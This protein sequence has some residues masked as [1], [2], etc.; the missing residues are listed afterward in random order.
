MN[1]LVIL[2]EFLPD[3]LTVQEENVHLCDSDKQVLI[4]ALHLR[5]EFS[6]QVTVL[7]HGSTDSEN[8]ISEIWSYAPDHVF[9]LPIKAKDRDTI[10]ES[11]VNLI[12][13]ARTLA[14]T[15]RQIGNFDLILF[16]RQA[17]DGDS[18][19]MASLV[20]H[21]LNIPLL[22][23]TQHISL[24][25]DRELEAVCID[26][27]FS[28]TVNVLAPA[29]IVSY[30]DKLPPRYPRMADIKKAYNGRC[31]TQY[32]SE[33][34]KTPGSFMLLQ[35]YLPELESDATTTF[36]SG[37]NDRE[38]AKQLLDLLRSMGHCL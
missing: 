7:A 23:Y 32:L 29:V 15:V 37:S 5:D 25:S 26:D 4:E 28:Y 34:T 18:I 21:Y 22:P 38:K 27:K 14:S 16:G 13:A 12:P 24:I 20:S 10:C 19:H 30:N 35:E 33:K 9:M 2:K 17:T 31:N 1:M 8:I 11:S 3:L 36:L 6:G